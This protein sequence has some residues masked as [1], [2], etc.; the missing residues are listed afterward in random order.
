MLVKKSFWEHLGEARLARRYLEGASGELVSPTASLLSAALAYQREQE[1][2]AVVADEEPRTGEPDIASEAI[3]DAISE[4]LTEI[5][6]HNEIVI[7]ERIAEISDQLGQVYGAAQ[8]IGLSLKEIQEAA[9]AAIYSIPSTPTYLTSLHEAAMAAVRAADIDLDTERLLAS[10]NDQWASIAEAAQ[11]FA[12]AIEEE[13]RRIPT[14]PFY[15]D[16]EDF[17][18]YISALSQGMDPA[19]IPLRRVLPVRIF[20]ADSNEEQLEE[21]GRAVLELAETVGLADSAEAVELSQSTDL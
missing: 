4:L 18:P 10:V 12:A 17:I 3:L 5:D 7:A 15:W 21:T 9:Q 19:Q 20:L 8:S 11:T 2:A 1:E 13:T 16:E 6:I 14:V